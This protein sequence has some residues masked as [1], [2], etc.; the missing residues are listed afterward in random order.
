MRV[1]KDLTGL[2][3]GLLTAEKIVYAKNGKNYWLCKC[4]C[5]NTKEIRAASLLNGSSKSCG[6]LHKSLIS[7]E[8]HY[9]YKH[10]K[11]HSIEH[12]I[13]CNIKQRCLNSKST[14]FHHYGGRGITMCD[15]WRDSFENFLEDMGKRPGPKLSIDRIDVNGN[16]EPSN[17]KWSTQSEQMRNIRMLKRNTSGFTGVHWDRRKSVWIVQIHM[18]EKRRI[19]AFPT[20]EEAIACRQQWEQERSALT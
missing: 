15:R 6:C 10:G 1:I 13:W 9:N 3:L 14:F 7:G 4:D 18:S 12:I 5:G 16:Y 11:A 20:K 19:K 17:C 8:N 2:K